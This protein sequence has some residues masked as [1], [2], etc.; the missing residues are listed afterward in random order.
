MAKE[1]SIWE[2]WR[3]QGWGLQIVLRMRDAPRNADLWQVSQ[4]P[5]AG[6]EHVDFLRC[7]A[8]DDSCLIDVLRS[9][10]YD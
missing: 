8:E 4:A 1:V 2:S 10:F 7:I 6:V 5:G 3:R 9:G